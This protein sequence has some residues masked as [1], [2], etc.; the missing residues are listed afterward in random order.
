MG[1]VVFARSDYD[2]RMAMDNHFLNIKIRA[3]LLGKSLLFMG[4]SFRDDHVRQI[5]KELHHAFQGKLP[6]SYLIAYIPS[7]ELEGVCLEYG[8]E[9]IAPSKIFPNLIDKEAFEKFLYEMLERTFSLKTSSEIDDIFRPKTP[10]VNRVISKM[11][12][13]L[14]RKMLDKEELITAIKKFRAKLDRT[15]I[16]KDLEEVVIQLFCDICK[17]CE[18]NDHIREMTGAAFNL[19]LS[20]KKSRIVVYVHLM[21]IGNRRTKQ[22]SMD[23]YY[24]TMP[25]MPR[26]YDMIFVAMAI[27]IL[28]NWGDVITDDY[29]EFILQRVDNGIDF[30]ELTESEQSFVKEKLDYAWKEKTTY[31]HPLKRQ[32]RLR[33]LGYPIPRFKKD[34][35]SIMERMMSSLPKTFS[36][37]YEE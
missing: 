36:I 6:K 25:G 7:E 31:E 15:L 1:I 9:Y 4:Y 32:R 8:I 23:W 26:E 17:R 20:E 35:D 37:S 18:N 19:L 5:F 27:D 11:E 22:G 3:D 21:A 33:E 34:F 2:K 24:V 30:N 16:P 10:S 12:I 29:R 13:E 14:L 28:R